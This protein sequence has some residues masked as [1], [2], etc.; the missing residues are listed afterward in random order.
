MNSIGDMI[1]RIVGDNVQ[2]DSSIDN[3]ESK[4]NKFGDTATKIG[5]SLS[6]F[7]TTPLI[8]LGVA[9]VKSS[10]QMEML[11]T[12]FSTMLGSASKAATLMADLKDMAAKTP[13]ETTDLANVTKSLLQ[14]GVSVNDILPTLRM[15]GDV[16]G[17]NA[18]KF[19]GISYQYAQMTAA[20]RL[21][22]G[23]LRS[24]V[25]HG[26]NPLQEIARTTGESMASLQQ[27]MARGAITTQMVAAAFKSAT[28]EG[29]KFYNGMNAASQTMEGLISTLK[30]D[31]GALGRSL[32][33]QFIPMLKNGIKELS[34][35]AQKFTALD[36]GTKN[37]ILGIA[38]IAAALGPA[39]IVIGTGIKLY[40]ALS[41]GLMGTATAANV[42]T[43]AFA[44]NKI[45]LIAHNVATGLVTVATNLLA[46]A[47]HVS[48][49][50]INGMTAAIAATGIGLLVIGLALAIN[51]I[52]QFAKST[53]EAKEKQDELNQSMADSQ[54]D[55]LVKKYGELKDTRGR[56]VEEE[57][58]LT[59]EQKEQIDQ[60]YTII[61]LD[62][63]RY[64][65]AEAMRE[66]SRAG[67]TVAAEAARKRMEAI[68]AELAGMKK[69]ETTLDART[70][71]LIDDRKAAET[72]YN[73]ELTLI[74]NLLSNGII[75]QEEALNRQ[76]SATKN[77][78]EALSSLGYNI[79][80]TTDI[81]AQA[82]RDAIALVNQLT[83]QLNDMSNSG[84]IGGLSKLDEY[85]SDF[86][87]EVVN[88]IQSVRE[89][90]DALEELN[91][92]V[93]YFDEH[94]VT[95][96]KLFDDAITDTWESLGFVGKQG[97]LAVKEFDDAL[98]DFA[99]DTT[100]IEEWAKKEKIAKWKNYV[101]VASQE[102]SGMMSQFAS[103]YNQDVKNQLDALDVITSAK[104]KANEKA[105]EDAL[106]TA[107][108]Q[109]KTAVELAQA[110]L[111]AATK[112]ND[113]K[114]IDAAKL[115]LQKAQIEKEFA[116]KEKAIRKQAAMEAYAIQLKQ[117]KASQGMSIAQA[118]IS[119]AQATLKA[120]ELGP[121]AGPIAAAIM[122]GLT[123]YQ[124]KT[125]S[126][127]TPPPAPTF[128]EGGIVMP[129]NGGVSATVAEA[130]RPEVIFPLDKLEQFLDSRGTDGMMELT[131]QMDSDVLLKKIFP[132]TKNRKVL[133]HANAVVS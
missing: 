84:G 131:V 8:G 18:A 12:S 30:D 62:K 109:E 122:A 97:M 110:E 61:R 45:A 27:K 75:P 112:A 39:L 101:N 87:E 5:R 107:G 92:E 130:G 98:E 95:S 115:A 78:A 7:V 37:F 32:A 47:M 22:G 25:N 73:E 116:D 9:A 26:F 102:I 15:L 89:F 126:S 91:E 19:A 21:L 51:K 43:S 56:M 72:A 133:I 125:I 74:K 34:V 127:Q 80:N 3:S 58:K 2:F 36:K 123:A 23:D 129:R 108:L 83:V 14:Y 70:K 57:K 94:G 105:K 54:A 85:A 1:V 113:K 38:G 121:I 10:A 52:I 33:D 50:A 111:D 59:K 4:L 46:G 53:K 132:A 77:Y 31:L 106:K 88:T 71:K 64:E 93:N 128:A 20:G 16:S 69:V 86:D 42:S 60:Y 29:G 82:L 11:E 63:L 6:L 120:L 114:A 90:D 48:T 124:I 44:L 96:V 68:D 35:L 67:N 81:G 66:A 24:M 40:G 13:F 100:D 65:Q 118:T 119:G 17:G 28:S 104:L 76:I 79:K 49:L 117:F 41:L 55:Y 99:T 103:I